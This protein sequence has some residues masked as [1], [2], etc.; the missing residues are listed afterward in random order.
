MS[1][2]R[3]E[4]EPCCG[5]GIGTQDQLRV[6]PGLMFITWGDKISSRT[7]VSGPQPPWL[8]F[9][10]RVPTRSAESPGWRP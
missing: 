7:F 1:R 4:E 2:G 6:T 10:G 8:A 5:L 9:P 3:N